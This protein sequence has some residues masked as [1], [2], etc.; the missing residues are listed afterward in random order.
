MSEVTADPRSPIDPQVN[1]SGREGLTGTA[2][3]SLYGPLVEREQITI[4]PDFAPADAQPA[5]RQDFPIDWPQDQY[6]ER[7]YFMKFMVLTSA[8]F[9]VGQ[10]W[11]AAQNWWRRQNGSY[12]IRRIAS[13]D[14]VAVGGTIVFTYPAEH[15][16]CLLVRTSD[17]EFVAFSQKCTHL[18]CAVIPRPEEGIFFCPCH[19]GRFDLRSGAPT[20]GPPRRP[21]PRILLDIRGRTIYAV[22]VEE[23]TV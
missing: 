13:V 22:G 9:A 5:W 23:R 17:T 19:E 6:V 10:L 16:P 14:D 2:P 11:I 20:A 18:S 21:L 7:R 4:A 15:D 12:E 1:S 3:A 8:A